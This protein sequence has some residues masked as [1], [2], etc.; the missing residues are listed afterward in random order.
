MTDH[1]VFVVALGAITPLPD[2]DKLAHVRVRERFDVVVDRTQWREGDL[3]VHI[4]PDY[5]VP[6]TPAFTA[7]VGKHTRIGVRR[8][9]GVHSEGL[10]VPVGALGLTDVTE[11]TDVMERL[12][13]TRYEPF[14]D[15]GEDAPPPPGAFATLPAY[16]VASWRDVMGTPAAEFFGVVEEKVHGESMRVVAVG[17]E[18]H[19]GSRNRWKR[20]NV[21]SPWA[22]ALASNPWAEALCRQNPG[23]CLYGEVFGHVRDMNYGRTNDSRGFLAFN[24]YQGGRWLSRAE[25]TQLVPAHY[26]VPV[27]GE[28][29]TRDLDIFA[30]AEGPT[31]VPGA[32]HVREGVVVKDILAGSGA[33]RA[34]KLHGRGYFTRRRD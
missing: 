6:P 7:I 25:F 14:P 13:I 33:L 22:A 1:H 11:G 17:E 10:L 34:Y 26:R 27:V 16:E 21:K 31:Q 3:A 19:L 28:G 24:A 4:E 2:T 18:I 15:T 29:Y 5:V 9:R 30:L 8:M 23:V 12:G 32:T 20:V